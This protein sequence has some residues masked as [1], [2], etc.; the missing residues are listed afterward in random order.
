M[1][2]IDKKGNVEMDE[3]EEVMNEGTVAYATATPDMVAH[4]TAVLKK[5]NKI[6]MTGII[7]M[8]VII[9]IAA[10]LC[11]W[12]FMGITKKMNVMASIIETETGQSVDEW[13]SSSLMYGQ[14]PIYD[15]TAVVSAY[16]LG[17]SSGLSEKDKYVFD[18][19]SGIIDEIITDGMSDYDK[20]KAVYDYL[21]SHVRYDEGRFAA[22]SEESTGSTAAL[23]VDENEEA[24]EGIDEDPYGED[25]DYEPYGVFKNHNAICVGNATTMKLF[26]D[27]LDIPC[28]V[29]HS[30]SQG[31]HAWNLVQIG[32]DWYHM[33]LTFDNGSNDPL[34]TYFNVPDNVKM[35][36]G[37]PWDTTEFPAADS[38][39]YS[40][41]Y[42]N[43]VKVDSIYEIPAIVRSKLDDGSFTASV[44][45]GDGKYDMDTEY[46]IGEMM[47][48]IGGYCKDAY[49]IS[50]AIKV[51]DDMTVYQ[52]GVAFY[53]DGGSD[54]D[55]SDGID[56]DKIKSSVDAVF[57]DF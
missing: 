29:I 34:Y 38:L 22:V 26:M 24:D 39:T 47:E 42:R 50:D 15:D 53:D 23:A 56:Y 36:S 37:Y 52:L 17:D 19:A 27:M 49:A 6:F 21:F 28:Y 51:S 16:K 46:A 20:E 41:A 54:D 8:A 44:I 33:D 55:T 40:Y 11:T 48:E 32:G 2:K 57:A 7:C 5:Q 14:H 30:T 25:Y 45:V 35:M 13:M 43:A 18:T 9:I 1:Y 4:N 10:L 12:N 3:R 31:E